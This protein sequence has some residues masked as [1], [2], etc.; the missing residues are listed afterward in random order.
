M[1]SR[2][3]GMGDSGEVTPCNS[4]PQTSPVIIQ[5]PLLQS[6]VQNARIESA[7][8]CDFHLFRHESLLSNCSPYRLVAAASQTLL[9][10]QQS[11]ARMSLSELFKEEVNV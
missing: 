5:L 10:C 2:M 6:A 7:E 3:P 9:A 4:P 1:V 8:R 11:V